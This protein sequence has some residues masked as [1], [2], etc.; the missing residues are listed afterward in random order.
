MNDNKEK[1]TNIQTIKMTD[2]EATDRFINKHSEWWTGKIQTNKQ[3]IR[4]TVDMYETIKHSEWQTDK[5]NKN[6]RQRLTDWIVIDKYTYLQPLKYSH[7]HRNRRTNT[8]KAGRKIKNG[9]IIFFYYF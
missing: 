8:I 7:M 6:D 3:R 1:Q 2:G 4:L 9:D 5:K